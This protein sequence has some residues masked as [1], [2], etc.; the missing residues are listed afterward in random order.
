[1]ITILNTFQKFGK[2]KIVVKT[3]GTLEV[4]ATQVIKIN[5]D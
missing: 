1:M 2:Y 4:D 5:I 3:V